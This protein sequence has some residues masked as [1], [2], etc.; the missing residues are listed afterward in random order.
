MVQLNYN[1]DTDMPSLEGK[2]IFITGGMYYL[3]LRK[4]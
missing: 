4:R 1:P 2:V 3:D